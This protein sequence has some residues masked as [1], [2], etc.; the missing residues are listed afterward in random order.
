MPLRK[1]AG[2]HVKTKDIGFRHSDK[3]ESGVDV[4]KFCDR[5]LMGVSPLKEQFAPTESSPVSLH[6]RMAGLG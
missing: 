5:N 4:T 2:K 3:I 1:H 6:K